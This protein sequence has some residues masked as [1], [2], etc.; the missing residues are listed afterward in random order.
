MMSPQPRA[1]AVLDQAPL[2]IPQAPFFPEHLR[3]RPK[4]RRPRYRMLLPLLLLPLLLPLGWWRVSSVELTP[5]P[6]LP[7]TVGQTLDGL[8]G[9]SALAL[10]LQWVQRQVAVWPGV[11]AVEVHLELPSALQVVARPAEISGS[12]AI[13]RGWHAVSPNGCLGVR[14]PAPHYPVMEGF[15]VNEPAAL[16]QG[17]AVAD[18]LLAGISSMEDSGITAQ[19]KEGGVTAV[20]GGGV[21]AR[22]ERVRLVMPGDLRVTLLVSDA[23]GV[24]RRVVAHVADEETGAQ[25]RWCSLVKA[26]A[27][28]PWS[29][30]R[31]HD[32]WVVR[33]AAAVVPDE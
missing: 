4:L 7:T 33:E 6:G 5:C 25:R 18:R 19:V 2:S 15:P 32:R 12:L 23:A 20:E 14:L 30:L 16:Q 13:A 8:I 27:A 28:P 11:A 1:Q 10:D 3:P 29:D 9:T 22:V 24:E 21:T 31:W 26:G 17:L